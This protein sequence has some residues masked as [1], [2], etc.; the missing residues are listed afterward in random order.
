MALQR[1]LRK[2]SPGHLLF[3][4]VLTFVLWNTIGKPTIA[5][6]QIRTQAD[7]ASTQTDS[8]ARIDIPAPTQDK[9][10]L[11]PAELD[12]PVSENEMA[13]GLSWLM[14]LP[15]GTYVE[16]RPVCSRGAEA[17]K[18]IGGDSDLGN[19]RLSAF[20]K[21]VWDRG[22]IYHVRLLP[23][24][25]EFVETKKKGEGE[26]GIRLRILPMLDAPA[27]D[28]LNQ[29]IASYNRKIQAAYAKTKSGE[30][31]STLFRELGKVKGRLDSLL[32]AI[33]NR[34]AKEDTSKKEQTETG[35]LSSDEKSGATGS[36]STT[37]NEP[38]DKFVA[39]YYTFF[40]EG[41]ELY[42]GALIGRRFISRSIWSEIVVGGN[43]H[44][45]ESKGV[46][47]VLIGRLGLG[48]G[49]VTVGALFDK[50]TPLEP[51]NFAVGF[52]GGGVEIPIKKWL[53]I[54]GDLL[55]TARRENGKTSD[56][57]I[58]G[59]LTATIKF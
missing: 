11:L 32:L 49:R 50:D 20:W 55:A 16:A 12:K 3:G 2:T 1:A 38:R 10:I 25:T 8:L 58:G 4:I 14:Q 29:I 52:I 18:A 56:L 21:Y 47:G 41:G 6:P 37:S 46:Q 43:P 57:K 36:S 40:V 26:R 9:S 24:P 28:A 45:Y 22:A 54:S 23:G 39:S 5:F 34:Q 44:P 19:I 15:K 7:S 31:D 13:F 51:F 48:P 30:I 42:H 53:S 35:K 27:R 59:Q 17:H 33:Q